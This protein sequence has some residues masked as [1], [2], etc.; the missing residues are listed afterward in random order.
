M[1]LGENRGVIW[2]INKYGEI[3]EIL[4]S[5]IETREFEKPYMHS[6]ATNHRSK[7]EV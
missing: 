6:P 7:E 5:A 1:Y 3:S 4:K 2:G